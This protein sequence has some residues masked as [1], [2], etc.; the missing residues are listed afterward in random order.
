MDAVFHNPNYLEIKKNLISKFLA[1]IFQNISIWNFQTSW[2]FCCC[3]GWPSWWESIG[4][5]SLFEVRQPA[6]S[7]CRYAAISRTSSSP[8]WEG[9]M[10]NFVA[11]FK[12]YISDLVWIKC[13]LRF[14]IRRK[15]ITF[16]SI[17]RWR[18]EV[19]EQKF[20]LFP[21]SLLRRVEGWHV[22]Y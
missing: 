3:W 1:L 18:A 7:P 17:F 16:Y 19:F 10:P 13:I 14:F 9:P 12:L 21:S 8:T 15:Q 4:H 22:V 20:L 2:R 11:I 6:V 5:E